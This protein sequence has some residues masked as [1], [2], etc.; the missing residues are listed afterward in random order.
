[1]LALLFSKYAAVDFLLSFKSTLRTDC[2][3][4]EFNITTLLFAA[5]GLYG[6]PPSRS[7][8]P[9]N[10]KPIELSPV[11]SIALFNKI[12]PLR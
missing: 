3:E 7:I 4:V 9:K 12:S 1:M 2:L 5:L 10:P 11:I 6:F 8:Y